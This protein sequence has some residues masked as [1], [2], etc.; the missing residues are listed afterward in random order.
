MLE[1]DK[2]MATK[3]G[4]RPKYSMGTARKQGENKRRRV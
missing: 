2:E 1:L 4:Q 3:N